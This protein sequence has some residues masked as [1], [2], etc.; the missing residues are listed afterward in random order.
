MD[1]VT[2]V[3]FVGGVGYLISRL[4]AIY[5][6]PAKVFSSN[7]SRPDFVPVWLV[8][9]AAV[10]GLLLGAALWPYLLVKNAVNRN[11]T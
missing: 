1:T 3:W 10:L 5:Q 8:I 7:H 9:V 4:I 11:R 2:V 6:D